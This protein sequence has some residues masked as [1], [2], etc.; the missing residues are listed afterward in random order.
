MTDIMVAER[1]KN[2]REQANF[3]QAAL[4]HKLG[5]TRSSVNAWEMGVSLPSTHYLKELASIFNVSADYLLGLDSSSTISMAGLSDVDV[6]MIY[7][8]VLY[9]QLK[10][11]ED[12]QM[13]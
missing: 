11:G 10:N 8:L 6:D 1:I 13:S 4:T 3:T 9:I 12:I 5:V 7:R 2:L